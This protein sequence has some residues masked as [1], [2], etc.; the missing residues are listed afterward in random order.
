MTKPLLSL[1]LETTGVDKNKDRIV[2]IS[3][4]WGVA[5]SEHWSTLINPGIPIP[6][7]A[8]DV[9]CIT[10]DMV[11]SERPFAEVAHIIHSKLQ[12]CYL[13]GF[14]IV[15]YDIPLLAAE[16]KRIGIDWPD[17]TVT[18]IDTH[19]IFK[20]R[21]PRTLSK[22]VEYYLKRPH[23]GAHG[24][25]ADAKATF[26]ILHAQIAMYSDLPRNLDELVRVV[27]GKDPSWVDGDGKLVWNENGEATFTMG[28][29]KGK[30]LKE[31]KVINSGYLSWILKNDFS[32]EL[33]Q[34]C[35][36]ALNNKYPVKD[37]T[38]CED[39]VPST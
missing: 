18:P 35:R 8:S 20:K 1:D 33:K 36:D 11:K 25:Y 7:G 26:E 10:D 37:T 19:L 34:I 31:V 32:E 21:E 38:P 5:P 24:A 15:G 16:F 13:T 14:N 22:A 29:V 27:H 28:K 23:E 30:T 3:I 9:H 39:S 6:K 2:E 4:V 12:N 17:D